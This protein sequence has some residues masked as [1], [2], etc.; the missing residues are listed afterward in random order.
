MSGQKGPQY[1]QAGVAIANRTPFNKNI[2]NKRQTINDGQATLVRIIEGTLISAGVI[3]FLQT[4]QTDLLETFLFCE[5]V[6]TRQRL[7]FTQQSGYSKV[8][9]GSPAVDYPF[10]VPAMTIDYT[11]SLNALP[12]LVDGYTPIT[13]A[14]G[15]AY[16]ELTTGTTE[17]NGVKVR[18][19]ASIVQA[20]VVYKVTNRYISSLL[21]TAVANWDSVGIDF[22][23]RSQCVNGFAVYNGQTL[24]TPSVVFPVLLNEED[25]TQAMQDAGNKFTFGAIEALIVGLYKYISD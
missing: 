10:N 9:V 8:A 21:T 7:T 6:P 11:T 24:T 15:I 25:Y 5:D 13:S 2:P 14:N 19:Y 18:G 20:P 17:T 23:T 3:P 4:P 16:G 12:S 22:S 1:E